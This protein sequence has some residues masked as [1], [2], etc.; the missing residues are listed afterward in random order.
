MALQINS[1]TIGDNVL[2]DGQP[3][4]I[5]AEIGINHNGDL[6]IAKRLVNIA[7]AAGC[8]AVKFQK[9]AIEIVCSREELAQP[10][11][12]PFGATYGDLRRGLEFGRDE[13]QEINACCKAARIPW[14][15]SC[16]DEESVN[17]VADFDVPCFTIASASL[18]DDDLLR[19]TRTTGK[20]VI[21][22]TGMSTIEEIDHAVAILGRDDLILM[23]SSRTYPAP[24]AELN[25]R[26]IHTL[27]A[28]YCIPVGYSGHET[29]IPTSVAAA[30][31]G[32]CCVER[33]VTLDRAMWGY[34]QAPSLE[35]E[36]L[37]RLVQDIRLVEAALGDGAKRSTERKY[38][39]AQHFGD[40]GVHA[41]LA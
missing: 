31:L 32:A 29:C 4:Y 35:A 2:G 16:C 9:R 26:A 24:C 13:Y 25:L 10:F 11:E 15:A 20:P 38:P 17:F 12:S 36:D 19:H 18:A 6:D 23:H 28:R 7:V 40:A 30:A 14:F 34:D 27:R 8:D 33:H 21:L 22:S 1:V 37:N 5:V 3:S 41:A 39:L